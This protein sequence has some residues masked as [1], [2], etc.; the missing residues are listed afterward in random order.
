MELVKLKPAT[1]DYIWAGSKLKKLGK[2][3]PYDNIAECWELSFHKDGPCII[4]SGI[5]KGKLLLEI[6]TAEDLGSNTVSFPF[7]P[8]LIKLIDSGDNLSVQVHPND[9]YA[10][11]HENSFGKTEMWYVLD[12]DEGCGLYVGLKEDSNKNEIEKALKE[13]S[14]LNLLNFYPVKKGEVYFIKSGTIHAIGKG[15]TVI[16]IQQNSNLTY[17]LY[18]YNRLGKDG[19]PRELHIE[20]ALKVIDYNKYQPVIFNGDIIGTSKYFTTKKKE[21][22]NDDV[23]IAPSTSFYSF[24]FLDGEGLINN[25]PYKKYDTFFLPSTKKAVIKGS[26]SYLLTDIEH[27]FDEQD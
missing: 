15:V 19:K 4:D 14:I 24:T 25:I 17:R 1:K 5:D 9:D 18:D 3:A 27:T 23:L 11:K 12:A 7:F 6:A 22:R 2:E 16:E 21:V 8:V 20:K 26:G 10:L 13:G